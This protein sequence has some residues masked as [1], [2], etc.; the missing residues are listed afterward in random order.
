[1]LPPATDE[2]FVCECDP[3]VSVSQNLVSKLAAF[4]NG[5]NSSK[6]MYSNH[7]V[8]PIHASKAF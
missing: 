4:H 5:S 7:P 3:R 2:V 6:E 8:S 1:M